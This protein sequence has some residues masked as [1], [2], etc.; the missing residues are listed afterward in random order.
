MIDIRRG[1]HRDLVFAT[2]FHF[3]ILFGYFM[4]RP[5][6]ESLG[7]NSGIEVV[8]YLFIGTLVATAALNAPFAWA[9]STLP[10]R[11]FVPLTYRAFMLVILGF[12]AVFLLRGVGAGNGGEPDVVTLWI[13]RSYYIF[14]TV[15]ALFNTMVFWAV[16]TDTFDRTQC[17]RLYPLV[18]IGGTAGALVGSTVA[19][20]LADALGPVANLLAEWTPALS[21]VSGTAVVVLIS[22]VLFESAIRC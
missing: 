11:R 5:A 19:W 7:L 8:A 6:R 3:F 13:S 16:M 9:V 17:A 12:G 2:L 15:F 22:I 14:V 4:L 18:A 1:E 21:R 20:W 10:R